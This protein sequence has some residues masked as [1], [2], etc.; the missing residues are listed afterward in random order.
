M[1]GRVDVLNA[2][3]SLLQQAAPFK[4]TGLR[5]NW[6]TKVAEQPALF[7]RYTEDEYP[8]REMVG[9]PAPPFTMKVEIWVYA[10]QPDVDVE[11]S[12]VMAPLIDAIGTVLKPVGANARQDLGLRGIVSHCWLEGRCL[13][14]D[15]AMQEDGQIIC[16][17]PVN[18]LILDLAG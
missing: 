14:E 9:Q 13:Y 6:V 2:L 15:G 7:I 1:T 4:T 17:L 3:F 8:V 16:I 12:A 18:I 11:T 5:L 10:R